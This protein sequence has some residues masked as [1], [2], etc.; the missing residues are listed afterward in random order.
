MEEGEDVDLE[1][2]IVIEGRTEEDVDDD[3]SVLL[4]TSLLGLVAAAGL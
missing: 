2:D 1:T 4:A 3:S